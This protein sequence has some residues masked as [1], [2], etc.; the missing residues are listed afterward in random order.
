MLW[1][2]IDTFLCVS[3]ILNRLYLNRENLF[4]S[5]EIL[6][7]SYE[8]RVHVFFFPSPDTSWLSLGECNSFLDL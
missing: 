3:R 1:L 6:G 4:G 2:D 5:P 7:I 8:S